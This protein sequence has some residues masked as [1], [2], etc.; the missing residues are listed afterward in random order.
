[1]SIKGKFVAD[2]ASFYEAAQK[3]EVSLD[4]I[5]TGAGKVGSGLDAA[6]KK[7]SGQSLIQQ[8]QLA[9]EAVNRL[10]GA[11]ILTQEEQ[12]KLNA[13]VSEAIAK[14]AALGEKAPKDLQAIQKQTEQTES[15]TTSWLKDFGTL[16]LSSFTGLLSAEAVLG[17]LKAAFSGFVGFLGDSVKS[18]TEAESA[19]R[20]MTVALQNLGEATPK[21]VQAMKELAGS[22]QQTTTYSAG[23][24]TEMQGLLIQVG[25]VGPAEMEGALRA[26]TDLASGLGIDL[27]DAT[28]LVAKAFEG[29]TDSL[30]KYGIKLDE[31]R[32]QA[33]GMPYVL[34]Q[35][36][37]RFGG[38]AQAELDTYAGKLAHVGN[39]W[40]DVKE[41]V[42]EFLLSSPLVEAALRAIDDAATGTAD[43]AGNLK[44]S[45]ADMVPPSL[46]PNLHEGI[47]YLEDW[48]EKANAAARYQKELNEAQHAMDPGTTMARVDKDLAEAK[49]AKDRAE[50]LKKER[51]DEEA[52][53]KAKRDAAA[54]ERKAEREAEKAK[55]DAIQLDKDIFKGLYDYAAALDKRDTTLRK[56]TLAIQD[57]IVKNRQ[58]KEVISATLPAEVS[59]QWTNWDARIK[60]NAGSLKTWGKIAGEALNANAEAAHKFFSKL[61]SLTEELGKLGTALSDLGALT[62]SQL[63][64]SLGNLGSA[65]SRLKESSGQFREG[66]T[67]MTSGGGL[68]SILGGF[69]SMVT[70]I[71]GYIAA[72]KAAWA[73]GKAI[74]GLFK[75]KGRD[76]VV[77]FADSMGGFDALQKKLEA[78]GEKG[79]EL[80]VKLTQGT[81][82]DNKEQAA[83]NIA[84]VTAALDEFERKSESATETTEEQARATIETA[85]EAAKAMDE[86]APRLEQNKS[87]WKEWGDSVTGDIDRVANALRTL[88][89]P[90]LSGAAASVSGNTGINGG[91]GGT[92]VIQ[93]DGRTIAEAVVPEIP[94]VVR[95]YGLT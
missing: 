80:W 68:T 29:N 76:M 13:L 87:Q 42:G 85:S 37:D 21:N 34:D 22:F 50:R 15:K 59:A 9:T 94:G 82:K 56:S 60:E 24:L 46:F 1:M 72:A 43:S 55:R 27:R 83:A 35:I 78:L 54:A 89:L 20:K 51:D 75:D 31:A 84:E 74:V 70:G 71:G 17:G 91:G 95:K 58:A 63:I 41:H 19:Q 77:D 67:S 14:Y 28:N 90:T 40:D 47:R 93:L 11:T 88:S 5:T 16:S 36:A 52:R 66:L 62:G 48:A 65:L 12:K 57:Y 7:F 30:K 64:G 32:V 44:K 26:A 2:F 69:S 3:A 61:P 92:A 79:A 33:E 49:A 45:W 23:L 38:Q 6:V 73:A 8:A 39:S 25:Q 18:F 86:I 4:K 81:G 53:Q 10:G